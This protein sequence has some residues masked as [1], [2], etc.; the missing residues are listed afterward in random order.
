MNYFFRR[1]RHGL[2][3]IRRYFPLIFLP[4]LVYGIFAA[5]TPDR[6]SISQQVS[7]QLSSP[8]S[9]SRTP[10][11]IIFMKDIAS[12][13]NKLFLDDFALI[14]LNRQLGKWPHN[15]LLHLTLRDLQMLLENSMS[16]TPINEAKVQIGY[17]GS[18][19]E[20][21]KMLV[22]FFTQR[23]ILRSQEGIAR[24]LRNARMNGITLQSASMGSTAPADIYQLA[25]SEGEIQVQRYRALWRNE[26]LPMAMTLLGIS[27]LIWVGIAGIV[28][29]LD[30]AF[31]SE[32]QIA[33]YMELP[34]LGCMPN[35]DQVMERLKKK[36]S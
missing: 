33:T 27:F 12:D 15:R 9:L 10:V 3:K 30:P 31:Q 16:I 19:A 6:F 22:G 25:R 34:I 8:V 28:E 21:G 29:W 14:D 23:L 32:R 11:D 4:A 20:L 7:V 13:P 5:L 2:W 35:L 18:D 24:S 1:Y 26:R 17:Y 36:Q